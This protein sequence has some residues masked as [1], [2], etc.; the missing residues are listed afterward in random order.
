MCKAIYSFATYIFVERRYLDPWGP[1]DFHKL[2]LVKISRV[3]WTTT[4]AQ[5]FPINLYTKNI[6]LATSHL[7]KRNSVGIKFSCELRHSVQ[8]IKAFTELEMMQEH[9]F[10]CSPLDSVFLKEV[11]KYE[12]HNNL[13]KKNTDRTK[14]R[15]LFVKITSPKTISLRKQLSRYVILSKKQRWRTLV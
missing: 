2:K 4:P 11:V 9:Y 3:S 14:I 12:M 15:R 6:G 5:T 10:S 8:S 7:L 1:L 13:P